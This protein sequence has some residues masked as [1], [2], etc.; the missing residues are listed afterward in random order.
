MSGRLLVAIGTTFLA[1]GV[2]RP[3]TSPKEVEKMF[4][5]EGVPRVVFRAARAQEA[6]VVAA[7]GKVIKIT[8]IPR[9]A[10]PGYHARGSQVTG[11]PSL[12]MGVGLPREDLREG[13]RDLD[14]QRD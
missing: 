14:A 11:N 8:G 5:A 3:K 13:A 4:P 6:R 9:G 2:D 12:Q 7:E 10:A 1:C